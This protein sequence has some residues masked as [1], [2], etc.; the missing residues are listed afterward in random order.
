[1]ANAPATCRAALLTGHGR[2]LEIAETPVPAELEPGALLVRTSAATICASDVHLWEGESGSSSERFPRI[3]GHEMTGRVARIGEGADRDSL[4]RPLREG[5]RIVWT[6]GFC[7]Q[8]ANCVIEHEQTLCEHRRGYMRGLAAEYPHLTGGF[9]EYCYVFPSSG[10]VRVPDIVPDELA[11]AAACALR[12]MVHGFDRLGRLDDRHAVA[13]Q[14]SGPLGLFSVALAARSGPSRIIVIGGPGPR[15]EVAR[16]WGATHTLD[17]A[18]EPDPAARAEIVREWTDGYGPD[19]VI[20]VSGAVSAFPEGLAMVRRG[21]RYLVVGQLHDR[22][23]SIRPGE[24][25]RKHVRIIGSISASVAHYH[26][27]LQFIAH[28]WER[29]SWTDLISNR[30]PLEEIN[31]A[32]RRMQRWEEIKPAIVFGAPGSRAGGAR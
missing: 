20:E 13:I 19:A 28:N 3:L 23:A 11:A 9:A 27:A 21:G 30:Y 5:D 16:R 2:P 10:R 1:M 18:D 22:E 4:G 25:T 17:I 14:G 29:F 15:L 31:E 12:T 32:M 8:C 24:I 7:G 6:H 26:R